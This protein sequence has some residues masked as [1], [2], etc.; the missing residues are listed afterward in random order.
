MDLNNYYYLN[1]NNY[2]NPTNINYLDPNKQEF[3]QWLVGF[4]DGDGSFTI[5]SQTLKNGKIK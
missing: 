2:S 1:N 3:Y 4:T 5:S